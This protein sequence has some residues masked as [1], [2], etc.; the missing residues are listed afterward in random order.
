MAAQYTGLPDTQFRWRQA[1]DAYRMYSKYV[2]K[3]SLTRIM[4]FVNGSET[5]MVRLSF[6]LHMSFIEE[7]EMQPG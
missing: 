1:P 6:A 7:D 2:M 3:L 4:S 5:K